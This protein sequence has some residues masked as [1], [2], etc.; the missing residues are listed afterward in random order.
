MARPHTEG[1]ILAG[2]GGVGANA[3]DAGRSGSPLG[4]EREDVVGMIAL[5]ETVEG[6]GWGARGR[7]DFFSFLAFRAF[8]YHC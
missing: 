2:V 8:P 6:T 7:R 5:D 4:D 1:G 3:G